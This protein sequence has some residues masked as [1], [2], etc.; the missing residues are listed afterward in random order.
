MRYVEYVNER[1]R[2]RLTEVERVVMFG[3]NIAAGSCI[4]GLTRGLPNH[5]DRLILNTPNVENTQVGVGFG[6]MLSG[7]SSILFL[8]Q[9]DFLLLSMD[10]LVNTHNFVRLSPPRASFTI[11][12]VVVDLGYQGIQS[13]LNNFGDFCSMGRVPGYAIANRH[14]ADGTIHRHLVAPG[15]R[16]IGVSQRLFNTEILECDAEPIVDTEGAIFQYSQGEDATIVAL[17]FSFPQALTLQRDLKEYG[18][19]ASLFSVNA[20]L[21]VDW[22]RIMRDVVRTG[23]AVILDDSKSAHRACY[24]LAATIYQE[25]RHVERVLVLARQSTDALL[26]PNPEEFVVDRDA[27]LRELTGKLA[28]GI[29]E[30]P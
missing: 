19:R 30:R 8:K 21:P 5:G 7:V 28:S 12:A 9:Q 14:D 6:L 3:E 29:S 11:V 15:F 27:V 23:R 18:L 13:S 25:C 20:A 22:S 24:H 1:I 16:I 26:C 10:H 4:G 17:N 2:A